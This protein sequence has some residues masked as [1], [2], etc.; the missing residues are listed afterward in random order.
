[1]SINIISNLVA[2]VISV[3][4]HAVV[5]YVWI[6]ILGVFFPGILYEPLTNSSSLFLLSFVLIFAN[7]TFNYVDN[8]LGRRRAEKE[9][10]STS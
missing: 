3:L 4:I 6:N 7:G 2:T 9:A 8:V 10:N 1:M 5:F